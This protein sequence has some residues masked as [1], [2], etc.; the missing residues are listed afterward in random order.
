VQHYI[1]VELGELFFLLIF[2]YILF[3]DKRS[4]D[5]LMYCLAAMSNHTKFECSH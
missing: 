3:I 5:E 2:F 1:L 4:T